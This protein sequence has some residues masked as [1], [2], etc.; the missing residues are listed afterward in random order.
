MKNGIISNTPWEV[1]DVEGHDVIVK[2]DDLCCPYPGPS[3]SKVRGVYRY[4]HRIAI[5]SEDPE[6]IQVGVTDASHSK[7][8]WVTAWVCKKFGMKCFNFYPDLKA[9]K[10][11]P[12]PSQAEAQKLGAV[13]MPMWTFK[14]V[15]LWYKSRIYIHDKYPETG[16]MLPSALKLEDSVEANYQE[17]LLTPKSLMKGTWVFSVGSGTIASGVIRAL[18]DN[19]DI[20]CHMGYTR[21]VGSI[22]KYILEYAEADRDITFVDEGLKYNSSVD[23]SWIPFPCNEYYDAKAFTWLCQN[24]KTL[25]QPIIFWNVGS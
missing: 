4:L 21:P 11:K 23:N 2:R 25:K 24:I 22:K 17:A 7:N 10:G 15:V 18:N 6:N 13:L 12:G 19:I 9:Y 1:Y 8:G 20:I 3:L 16:I 14:S 5:E